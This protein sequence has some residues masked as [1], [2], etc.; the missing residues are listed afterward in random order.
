MIELRSICKNYQTGDN[1]VKALHNVSVSF[2][3]N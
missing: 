3:K 2:R 1:V